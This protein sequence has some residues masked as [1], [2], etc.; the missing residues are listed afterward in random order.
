M[1]LN[2]FQ[3][4]IRETYLDRDRGRGLEKTFM[5]FVEEVGEL[6]EVLREGRRENYREEFSDVLAWLVTLV[7][8][9]GMDLE[10]VAARYGKGCPRCKAIP[11]ACPPR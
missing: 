4:V 7:N 10:E 1:K 5:W 9:V 11:C 3:E 2:E 6:A 8:I